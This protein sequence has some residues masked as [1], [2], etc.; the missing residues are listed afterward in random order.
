LSICIGSVQTRLSTLT[1]L[2]SRRIIAETA[3]GDIF[4]GSHVSEDPSHLQVDFGV[5]SFS[6][7][8]KFYPVIDVWV[9]NIHSWY[10]QD[11]RC[12]TIMRR[13]DC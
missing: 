12:H 13:K 2:S 5:S 6:Y 1:H 11:L 8:Y 10:I 4:H 3:M 9:Q 7:N